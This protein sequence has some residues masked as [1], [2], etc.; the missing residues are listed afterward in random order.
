MEFKK[1]PKMSNLLNERKPSKMPTILD[2]IAAI[3]ERIGWK[4]TKRNTDKEIHGP[5]TESPY[6][7]HYKLYTLLALNADIVEQY[8]RTL[9]PEFDVI[10]IM[11]QY[12]DKYNIH[13]SKTFPSTRNKL[14]ETPIEYSLKSHE[15]KRR[16]EEDERRR[17][18]ES[19]LNE[20]LETFGR[21]NP[22]FIA[23]PLLD[24]EK[25]ERRKA[26]IEC[27]K[28]DKENKK[29]KHEEYMKKRK[30]R[31]IPVAILPIFLMYMPSIY[32][33]KNQFLFQCEQLERIL[34]NLVSHSNYD[35]HVVDQISAMTHNR[36]YA[37]STIQLKMNECDQYLTQLYAFIEDD[38][39]DKLSEAIATQ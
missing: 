23:R 33:K 29:R 19:E 31:L 6:I 2:D 26:L 35:V 18:N 30:P 38:A 22:A 12:C 24:D 36:H 7:H 1:I 28:I 11:L 13:H 32:H 37:I 14:D 34:W 39:I 3:Y 20:G 27:S 4:P 5:I 21:N 8:M 15:M 17:N 10:D 16:Q 25:K 9:V